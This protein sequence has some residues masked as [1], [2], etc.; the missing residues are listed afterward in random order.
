MRTCRLLIAGLVAGLLTTADARSAEPVTV[1]A[2]SSLVDVLTSIERAFEAKTGSDVRISFAASS[3]L[4]HQIE[5]GAPADLYVSADAE[6]VDY[7]IE[8]RFA[9]KADSAILAENTLVLITS[10]T[11][12]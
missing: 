2:A 7:L 1:F 5:R 10:K 6:W 9:A 4:A 8:R 3:V 11:R 12:E